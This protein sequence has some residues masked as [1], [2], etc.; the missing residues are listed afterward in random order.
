MMRKKSIVGVFLERLSRVASF[1]LIGSIGVY[2]ILFKYKPPTCRYE[3]TCSQYAIDAIEEWG[4][5][6]G[7]FLALWR[8]LRCHPFAKQ[9]VD[10]VKANPLK[11]KKDD[12]VKEK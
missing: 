11:L 4:P 10:T 12:Y 9:G 8:I 3:P 1:I 6:R 5:F 7:V 2:R